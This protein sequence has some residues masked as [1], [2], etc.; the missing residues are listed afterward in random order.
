MSKFF[1]FLIFTTITFNASALVVDCT[2]KNHI[3]FLDHEISHALEWPVKDD[4]FRL[5]ISQN[6]VETDNDLLFPSFYSSTKW[7]KLEISEDDFRSDK[8]WSANP[9]KEMVISYDFGTYISVVAIDDFASVI[10]ADCF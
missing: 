6:M 9:T 2:V 7:K 8:M 3:E 5:R 4:R 10:T 1:L